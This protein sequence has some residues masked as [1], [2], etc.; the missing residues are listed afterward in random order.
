MKRIFKFIPAALA[1]VALSSCSN[2]DL[3]GSAEGNLSQKNTLK[4]TVQQ[5]NDGDITRAA[6]LGDGNGMV[7]QDGDQITVYDDMLF[8]YDPYKYNATAKAFVLDEDELEMIDEPA[9]ALFPTAYFKQDESTNWERAT[10]RV[11]VKATIDKELKYGAPSTGADKTMTK[12]TYDPYVTSD[13]KTAYVSL[14]PMWG[15]ASKNGETTEATMQYMTAI[16]KVTLTNAQDNVNYLY[17]RGFKDIAGTKPAQLSGNFKAYLSET[18]RTPLASTTLAG[19]DD[20]STTNNYIE[21]DI[22]NINKATSIIYVPVPVGHYGK[23][24]VWATKE[25]ITTEVGNQTATPIQAADKIYQFVDK[26]FEV[27]F[28]GA[29]TKKQYNVEVGTV[30]AINNL[31]Q[32]NKDEAKDNLVFDGSNGS[33]TAATT[34]DNTIALPQMAAGTVELKL[35]DITGNAVTIS[36][37]DFSKKFI[38]NLKATKQPITINLPNADV[39]LAGEYNA[40][41]V[42]IENAKSLTFGDG[43]APA[44]PAT[45]T[46]QNFGTIK[47]YAEVQNNIVVE[48]YAEVGD[49][50]LP[51]NHRANG[52]TVNENGVA[53]AITVK[54]SGLELA[55]TTNITVA[56]TSGHIDVEAVDDAAT[57][58]NVSGKSSGY[59]AAR[60]SKNTGTI[61]VSGVC[62]GLVKTLGTGTITVSGVAKSVTV[63]NDNAGDITISGAPNYKTATALDITGGVDYAKVATVT[64]KGNV[65]INLDGEGAAI[66]TSVTFNKSAKLNLTQGYVKA[67]AFGANN[68]TA[69]VVMAS[70]G[71]YASIA[72]VPAVNA[73]DNQKVVFTNASVWNGKKIGDGIASSVAASTK[74]TITNDWKGYVGA[75]IYTATAFAEK[76]TGDVNTALT[77]YN[78]ITLGSANTFAAATSLTKAFTGDKS[79]KST[80]AYPIIKDLNLGTVAKNTTGF[81]LFKTAADGASIEN[82]TF[83]GITIKTHNDGGCSNIG[84]LIGIVTTGS[85]SDIEIKNVA[86]TGTNAITGT[87]LADNIG[88]IIGQIVKGESA[89][90][91]VKLT[92]V[93]VAGLTITGYQAL[94]GLVGY[95]M[96]GAKV[97]FDRTGAGTETDGYKFNTVSNLKFTMLLS[98]KNIDA[99]YAKVGGFI[100]YIENS[101]ETPNEGNVQLYS[102]KFV[103]SGNAVAERTNSVYTVTNATDIASAMV[104]PVLDGSTVLSRQIVKGQYLIGFSDN[105]T[106]DKIK[107]KAASTGTLAEWANKGTVASDAVPAK[108]TTCLDYIKN[109]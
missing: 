84:G 59:I 83:N 10:D 82:L 104:Y 13:G 31:L 39:V 61:V 27:K 78:D 80:D 4:V 24:D 65:T 100:G 103:T 35:N 92:T 9:Y 79:M 86:L 70:E 93:S 85:T 46:T 71:K 44:S 18:G 19:I 72:T 8:I 99:N 106:A 108:K 77:V 101:T 102:D 55:K 3:F 64:T 81:G 62:T 42:T 12:N 95:V 97:L 73:T 74:T 36:G 23:L 68:V 67:I 38:L 90:K 26:D 52:I 66:G 40:K 63:D 88:G 57:N 22:S 16:I 25:K 91:A 98:G 60:G 75:S 41:N 28:Y 51:E 48:Q 11:W 37:S 34:T 96:N 69:S 5:I 43:A 20:A 33:A 54:A 15:T 50:T 7:W 56:G 2:D 30:T 29:L 53:G 6:N 14:L 109:F 47:I 1:V 49:L 105:A 76:V 94:G 87:V 32:A 107:V 58:V 21:V 17:V 89:T 45:T